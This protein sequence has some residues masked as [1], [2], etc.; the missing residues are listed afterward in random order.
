M[1]TKRTVDEM[2]TEHPLVADDGANEAM[3]SGRE[4]PV[5][6]SSR[7]NKDTDLETKLPGF[8]ENISTGSSAST[9]AGTTKA[10]SGSAGASTATTKESSGYAGTTAGTTKTSGGSAGA[11]SGTTKTSGGSAG[12][13]GSS[14]SPGASPTSAVKANGMKYY[15]IIASF[16]TEGKA[17]SYLNQHKGSEVV[18]DA[19]IVIRDGRVRV[20]S[21]IFSSEKD[22]Q[23]YITKISRNPNHKDAWLYI[24][25]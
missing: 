18:A 21:K 22:A 1:L 13:S 23:S 11:T 12:A 25:P 5:A 20:Y 3:A 24:G 8:S 6:E 9:S 19:G 15:V 7:N 4:N 14:K 17:Q 2:G 10:S 16:K